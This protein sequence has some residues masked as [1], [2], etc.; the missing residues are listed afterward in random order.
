MDQFSRRNFLGAGL[1][2]GASTLFGK[3]TVKPMR[4]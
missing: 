1:V 3:E 4:L 2:L